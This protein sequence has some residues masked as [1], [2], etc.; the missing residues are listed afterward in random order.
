[1]VNATA[2]ALLLACSLALAA[3]APARAQSWEDRAYVNIS[4]GVHLTTDP[5]TETL[6]PVIY[7]E[8]AS[9]VTS[10]QLDRGL[11]PLDIAGGVRVWKGFG[12]GGAF[13]QFSATEN[14]TLDA[15]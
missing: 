1:M 11:L 13:T 15:S 3:P 4:L 9:V 5:Q 10:R 12:L 8:R 14:G 6:A 7:D 2:R